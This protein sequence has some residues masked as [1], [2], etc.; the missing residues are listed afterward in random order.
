MKKRIVIVSSEFGKHGGGLSNNAS[1]L[2][3]LLVDMNFDVE[4]VISSQFNLSDP[5]LIQPNDSIIHNKI[6][7]SSGGYNSKL[8]RDL[9]FRGHLN[10]TL[11]NL[12]HTIPDLIISFGAG[13]NGL[14]ASEL[15]S[16]LNCK[17]IIMPRGSELNLAISNSDLIHC[18]KTC[19]SK[20]SSVVSV[21]NE[22]LDRAKEIYYSPSCVYKVI[23]NTINFL[24]DNKIKNSSSKIILGTGAKYLNEKKGIFNLIYALSI[25]NNLSSNKFNLHLCGFIDQDLK[26]SYQDLIE[27]LNL[28]QYVT[29]VGF[30]ARDEFLVEIQNWD[31]A[32][33]ASICEGFSNSIGDAIS[34]GISF[35]ISNTGYIAEQIYEDY[36]ELVFDNLT[37]KSI[38]VKIHNAYF[39]N[40]INHLCESAIKIIKHSVSKESI[41]SEWKSFIDVTL[42]VDKQIPN[43]INTDNVISLMLHEI[44]DSEFSGVDLPINKFSEF[45]FVVKQTGYKLC[46]AEEYFNSENKSNLIICTFDDGYKSVFKLALPILKN[47]SFTATVFVCPKH[48]GKVNDWNPK[49][50][51]TRFHMTL[52]ELL[53]LKYEGWEI[54]SHGTEHISFHRL[55]ENEILLSV[56]ESKLLLEKHFGIIYSFAYPYG[57]TSQIIETIVKQHYSNVFTTNL[58]GTHVLL[59]RH[60]IKRYIFDELQSLYKK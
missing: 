6:S 53:E 38:A 45:C 41:Y 25:L 9:F 40:N 21:S 32:L 19:L 2:F 4:V 26:K 50:K 28:N 58:G 44:S 20:A 47:Y 12:K 8:Q 18:N 60:R 35:M 55:D 22:L 48:I 14:F 27:K 16:K 34:V 37:P 15:S 5:T 29:F 1:N 31:I 10:N 54:G 3:Q 56:K 59:D 46:S 11:F 51:L 42:S 39:N 13:L 49:D 57:D 23:P 33:Q 7:V 30:L 52:D 43:S 17:L 36:P 24:I